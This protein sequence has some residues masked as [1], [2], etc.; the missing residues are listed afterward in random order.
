MSEQSI[1][2]DLSVEC[3]NEVWTLLEKGDRTHE[4][5]ELMREMA[6]ASLFHWMKREDCT[7]M[8]LSI[9]LWQVSRVHAVLGDWAMANHYG[10]ECVRV[11]EEGDLPPFFKGYGYEAVSRASH[12][13][14]DMNRFRN[15]LNLARECLSGIDDEEDRVLLEKDISELSER[16]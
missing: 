9:G 16:S 15:H 10:E 8:N 3:F 11:S 12:G 14:S 2:A 7:P 5:S 6:H 13:M 4:E 1:H